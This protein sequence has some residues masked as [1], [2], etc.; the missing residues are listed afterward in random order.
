MA[1]FSKLIANIIATSR[2]QGG[3]IGWRYRYAK[4]FNDGLIQFVEFATAQLH[5]LASVY[6][7]SATW[8]ADANPTLQD[9]L[10]SKMRN[11]V[12]ESRHTMADLVSDFKVLA[13]RYDR[14]FPLDPESSWTLKEAVYQVDSG[15]LQELNL[16]H[17]RAHELERQGQFDCP[18]K[19][20]DSKQLLSAIVAI[21]SLSIEDLLAMFICGDTTEELSLNSDF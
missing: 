12:L 18:N 8:P 3:N 15:I 1:S 6:P 10:S 17:E 19:S 11:F 9:D 21:K 13:E 2:L 20:N 7:D 5:E 14:D 4:T 16:L